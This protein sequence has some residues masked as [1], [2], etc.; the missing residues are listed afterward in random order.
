MLQIV[1]ITLCLG[2]KSQVLISDFPLNANLDSIEVKLRTLDTK[3]KDF[4][5]TLIHKVIIEETVNFSFNSD[6]VDHVVN[7]VYNNKEY[8]P[9]TN[10]ADY[11]V[12][13]NFEQI[14]ENKAYE[15]LLPVLKN[16]RSNSDTVGIFMTLN[17]LLNLDIK[18]G[19]RFSK[20]DDL[21][22]NKYYN[23]A[24]AIAKVSQNPYFLIIIDN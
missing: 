21:D 22:G 14:E 3:S 17:I 10:I 15:M 4:I 7:V 24:Y 16:F 20:N 5:H 13:S 6:N 1:T 8:R 23:E 12:A 2:E 9:Y 19:S 11:L 18:T